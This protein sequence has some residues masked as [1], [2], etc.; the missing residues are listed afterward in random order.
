VNFGEEE[1]LMRK[2]KLAVLG[3]TGKPPKNASEPEVRPFEDSI[4]YLEA[5]FQL[6]G[7]IRERDESPA[8]LS[9]IPSF[10]VRAGYLR[11]MTACTK[12]SVESEVSLPVEDFVIRH[13]LDVVDR[14]IF[15]AL[16]R[17]ALDPV[18]EGGIRLV[19]LLR[20]LGADSLARRTA[21]FSRLE[22]AGGLRDI[23][24]IHCIPYADLNGRIYRLAPWLIGPLTTGLGELDGTPTL[25]PDPMETVDRIGGEVRRL[26]EA[27]NADMTQSSRL[28]N[29]P[30]TG[31]GWDHTILRR[32]R[33]AA[34]LEACARTEGNPI[35]AEIRRFDLD[36][37]ERLCWAVL[38]WDSMADPVGVPVP[39]LIRYCGPSS[40]PQG[41]AERL[42]GPASKLGRADCLRFNKADIPLLRRFVWMSREAHGRIV[43]WSREDF[44]VAPASTGERGSFG[45]RA[46]GFDAQGVAAEGCSTTIEKGAA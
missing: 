18:A 33:L 41:A 34:R 32:K 27:V 9:D 17:A 16:L 23:C 13:Q 38:L 7:P 43:P 11:Y 5:W 29:G 24:A 4:Q 6:L 28:W 26:V 1:K 22:E 40:G 21:V 12:A 3:E 46:T 25:G 45:F 39:R 35:G 44:A 8:A 2:M 36:E 42:L 37:E 19:Y 20:A 15:L 31:G 14:L 30:A 10:D